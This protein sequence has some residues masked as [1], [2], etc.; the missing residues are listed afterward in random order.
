MYVYIYIYITYVLRVC[1]CIYIYIYIYIYICIGREGH[2]RGPRR[3]VRVRAAGGENVIAGAV[4]SN[5]HRDCVPVR[6]VRPDKVYFPQ[7]PGSRNSRGGGGN[8]ASR[9]LP[10]KKLLNNSTYSKF[11]KRCPEKYMVI[12][13]QA[14][15]LLV[16]ISVPVL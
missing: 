16:S 9:G 12:G 8:F 2:V 11:R 1:M 13:Q 10:E 7:N 5:N 14:E 15:Y 3:G 6:C 4:R